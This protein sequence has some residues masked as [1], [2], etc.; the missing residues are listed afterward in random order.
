MKTNLQFIPSHV[1]KLQSLPQQK[2]PHIVTLVI[3]PLSTVGGH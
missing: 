3:G 1:E 2:Q